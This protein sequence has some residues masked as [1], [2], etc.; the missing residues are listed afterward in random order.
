VAIA[1][2]P[3]RSPRKSILSSWYDDDHTAGRFIEAAC[4]AHGRGKLYDI[5]ELN[6]ARI[7]PERP[8]Q[9]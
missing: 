3:A 2:M 8:I 7:G 4:R 1:R 5:A 9:L 6:K